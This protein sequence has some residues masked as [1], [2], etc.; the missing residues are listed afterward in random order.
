ME[1]SKVEKKKMV[2]I[3]ESKKKGLRARMRLLWQEE[4]VETAITIR[5]LK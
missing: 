4:V 5:H 3:D 1:T 2:V